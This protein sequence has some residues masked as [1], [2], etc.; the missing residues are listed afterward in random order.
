VIVTGSDG[1]MY[2]AH[3][4]QIGSLGSVDTGEV[5]GYVGN[6]GDAMGGPMHLHFEWHPGGGGAVDPYPYLL[7]VC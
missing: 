1:Y 7:E 2:G 6:T 5:I 3:L 4:S